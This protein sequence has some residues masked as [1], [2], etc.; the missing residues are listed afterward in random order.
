MEKDILWLLILT[1]SQ[2]G[3]AVL[4]SVKL[5]AA[6]NNKKSEARNNP[7]PCAA[8]G[9]RLATVETEVKNLRHD[10]EEDHKI[11]FMKLDRLSK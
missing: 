11:I 10:N 1:V 7:H 4:I 8:H 3:Q 6:K 9:E 2:L 5:L